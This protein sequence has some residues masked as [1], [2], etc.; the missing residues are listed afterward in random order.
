M[1]GER[2]RKLND[3]PELEEFE[4][5]V[6]SDYGRQK[7]DFSSH[8]EILNQLDALREACRKALESNQRS[9]REIK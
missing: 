4:R 6:K 9:L 3:A 8:N 7:I 2:M 1:K 5:R